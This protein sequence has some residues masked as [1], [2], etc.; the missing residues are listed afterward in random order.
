M[1][2]TMSVEANRASNVF[3]D[4]FDHFKKLEFNDRRRN[5]LNR[6]LIA[7]HSGIDQSASYNIKSFEAS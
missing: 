3:G 2:L 6:S 1:P 7:N 4:A 5:R